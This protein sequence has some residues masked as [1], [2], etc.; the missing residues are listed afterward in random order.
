MVDLNNPKEYKALA[1]NGLKL[2]K[3]A[4]DQFEQLVARPQVKKLDS[5]LT[6]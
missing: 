2:S 5:N 4:N 3:E 6:Q 1:R